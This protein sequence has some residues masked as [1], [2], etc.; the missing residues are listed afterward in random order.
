MDKK[1]KPISS[2]LTGEWEKFRESNPSISCKFIGFV[3]KDINHNEFLHG[4]YQTEEEA[5]KVLNSM[6]RPEMS[7]VILS[8]SDN[9]ILVFGSNMKYMQENVV[10]C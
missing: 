1:S 3:I 2:G 6:G 5:V 7:V 8:Q 10:Y 9:H 4:L